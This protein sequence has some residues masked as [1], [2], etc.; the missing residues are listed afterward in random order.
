MAL[1]AAAARRARRRLR[2]VHP[3]RRHRGRGARGRQGHG[4]HRAAGGAA[5]PAV[6][7]AV[8]AAVRRR[9]HGH[10]ARQRAAAAATSSSCWRWRS[11]SD[12]QPGIHAIAGDTDGVDG[13]EEIAGAH[14]DARH[15]GARA[16]RWASSRA[17]GLAD[18]DGHGFFEAL[19][20][21]VVTGPTLTNV[22]DFRAILIDGRDSDRSALN[23]MRRQRNAKIVATLG[24]AS[25]D[26]RHHPRAVRRRR[27]RVPAELQP[28]HARRAPRALR[29][30]S[31]R[32][33]RETGRPIAIL[34][35][36]QGPKLRVG[37]FADGPVELVDGARVPP[38]PRSRRRATRR[39]RRCRIRRSSR[40]WSRAPTCCSTTARCGC[41]VEHCGADFAETR[42]DRRRRAVRPQGRQRARR[43]AAAVGDDRQ[44]P[45]RPRLRARRSAS[46]G[47]RC[48]SCSAPED[49]DEVRRLIGRA[50]PASSPSSRS[51]R[52]SSGSTRSS[53]APTRVM[54]ARGDLGVEMPPE[55]VPAVQKRIVRA[56]RAA[57]KPVI[58]ATQ[59]LESMVTRADAD[60]RRGLRRRHR[61][62]RRRRRGDAVGRDG[63]GQLS[64]R[65][66]G[67]DG[68]HHP[69][70]REGPVLPRGHRRQP[71]AAAAHHRRRDLRRAARRRAH[72]VRR[73]DVTYTSSGSTSMRA[74][75]ERPEAPILG[76][77]PDASTRAPAGAGLGR[78]LGVH[79]RDI[80]D[81]NTMTDLACKTAVH[82]GFAKPGD[83]VVIAAGV[84]FGQ[85]GTTNM[86]RIAVVRAER[87][88]VVRRRRRGRRRAGTALSR[89]APAVG[90]RASG[91]AATRSPAAP[92]S[93]RPHPRLPQSR[94]ARGRRARA[95]LD[96]RGR[97]CRR[98]ST[99]SATA[100]GA[101]RAS[102]PGCRA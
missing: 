43:R 86:L 93:R 27:R 26:R 79:A 48:R 20:D 41:T 12:G 39:A 58:V 62:L 25:S 91:S 81:I 65:G 33:E 49:I 11:R 24:P 4:R 31:A 36:L 75:R 37:T 7:G 51:R 72:G 8:R 71:P 99:R 55:Q 102:G 44:G 29:R 90:A 69:R 15:A 85:P 50:A 53:R 16:G 76:L 88:A 89:A 1:E 45:R 47:S 98:G 87:D 34:L 38:R 14:L 68:P 84:P 74:A 57:G 95:R 10:R 5:R 82:E 54:V 30:R 73:G 19:G 60:A 40:R 94:A 100:S 42:V 80:T 2:D 35:D 46:T 56:C 3:R 97:A 92:S 66:G 96:A 6:R 52:R 61:D 22:N 32:I 23:A 21:S 18:N 17:S 9:D 67:D 70:G 77:T 28:R 83:N 101:T 78:A 63:V 59:M 64:G 13:A